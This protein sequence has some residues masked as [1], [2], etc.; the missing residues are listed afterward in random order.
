MIRQWALFHG[1]VA[2]AKRRNHLSFNGKEPIFRNFVGES[3]F[4][5]KTAGKSADVDRI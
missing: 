2:I 4:Y 1:G 5:G 3:G